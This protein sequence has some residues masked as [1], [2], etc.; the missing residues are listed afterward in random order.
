M[1]TNLDNIL[2][3]K[4]LD[5]LN[6]LKFTDKRKFP[7]GH[8]TSKISFKKA[9]EILPNRLIN[10]IEN[11]GISK[12]LQGESELLKELGIENRLWI[13]R[14]DKTQLGF[15]SLSTD[16]I[17]S[18]KQSILKFYKEIGFSLSRKQDKLQNSLR[19]AGWIV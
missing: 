10:K 2:S 15:F 17:I 13:S 9:K 18:R 16:L 1:F 14:I 3:K 11:K 5:E 12:L 7:T 4:E 6:K 8:T 19:E